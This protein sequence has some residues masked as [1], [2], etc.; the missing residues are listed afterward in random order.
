MT[1][2]PH[3]PGSASSRRGAEAVA[4]FVGTQAQRIAA[5]V[6]ARGAYGATRAEI[7]DSTGI[8]LNAVCGRV[9]PLLQE[10][11]LRR[12]GTRESDAGVAVEVLVY[13]EPEPVQGALL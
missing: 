5:F 1:T 10:G 3:Q 12:A 7:A 13:I 8:S 6:R 4:P 11:V 2:A 9:G